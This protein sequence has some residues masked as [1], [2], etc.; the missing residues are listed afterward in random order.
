MIFQRLKIHNLFSYRGTCTFELAPPPEDD[1]KRNIILIWGRN[2]YGK[3]SFINSLKLALAG[4]SDD[5]RSSVHAG[6]NIKRD[7]YLLGMGD[8]WMGVFNRQARATGEKTF[9]VSLEWIEPAGT[10]TLQRKWT[11]EG[12][13]IT[14]QL[15]L[16]PSF[17]EKP[18]LDMDNILEGESRAFIQ[19]RLPS[20][21]LP[22]FIY[23]AERVQQLAE[24]NREGQMQ[25]MEQLLDLVN[26][27][28]ISE[29]LGKNLAAWK[30]ES[31]DA[32]QHQVD[33]QRLELEAVEAERMSFQQKKEEIEEDLATLTTRIARVDVALQAKRQFA[34]QTEAAELTVNRTSIFH[35]LEE[36]SQTFFTELTREAPLAL[37]A[38]WMRQAMMELEKIV[39]HPNRRLN[40][41]I[42]KIL[43]DLP[44]RV[45]F[46]PPKLPFNRE[47]M[48]AL[49]R[50]LDKVIRSYQPDVEDMTE[51]LF[52]LSPSRAEELLE[53][54]RAYA[55]DARIASQWA[56]NLL[57][58]RRLKT[59]LKDIERKLND[60]SNLAPTE[61]VQFEQKAN[62]RAHLDSQRAELQRKLGAME[63]QINASNRNYNHK[64]DTLRQS[65]RAWNEAQVAQGKLGLG[66]RLKKSLEIYRELLKTRRRREIEE[67][68]N[69]RFRDLMTSHGLIHRIQVKEDF[70]LHYKDTQGIPIGMGNISAGMKQLV[71]Q[72]LLWGLK[73]VAHR[74][75]PVIIDT[76]LARID[77]E[78]Q[79]NLITRY[80][81]HAGRQVI[82][83]PTDSELDR[84]K[85]ELI[86]PYVYR[87]YRLENQV[88]DATQVQEGGYY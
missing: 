56:N 1:N 55:V 49:A 88:G 44:K 7:H 72:A 62:E 8:E 45:L 6:R 86:R 54:V 52:H 10:V 81:P 20:A 16:T 4:V 70:S 35:Q 69:I 87:Q 26:V 9:G 85:Y 40:D 12:K 28:V 39:K 63:E 23:D 78:H 68:I 2:G 13:S 80:F 33:Q 30:R 79:N 15:E 53:I 14:E 51:G 29:Y 27:D 37:S 24:A 19:E 42:D 64:Q 71:A 25:Q 60:V 67:A 74:D 66:Q 3:T 84:E 34:L 17:G 31:G 11:L 43:K 32:N 83:L 21:L 73:D 48:G 76:P 57:E 47:D 22:F 46:D 36:K 82:V 5:L 41:E 77:R 38:N 58:I 61:R 75:A 65:E 50:K 18:T 59:E